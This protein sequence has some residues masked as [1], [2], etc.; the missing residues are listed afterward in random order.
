MFQKEKATVAGHW[1]T[2]L[3]VEVGVKVG[4]TVWGPVLRVQILISLQ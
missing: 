4:D 2:G 3:R 1:V